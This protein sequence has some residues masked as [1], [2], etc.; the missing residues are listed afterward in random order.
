VPAPCP[1]GRVEPFGV[2]AGHGFDSEDTLDPS[3][4]FRFHHREV[5]TVDTEAG[6]PRAIVVQV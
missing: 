1:F 5:T 2:A 6:G 4:E 3:L